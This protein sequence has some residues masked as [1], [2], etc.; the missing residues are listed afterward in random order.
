MPVPSNGFSVVSYGSRSGM[1]ATLNLPTLSFGHWQP[2]YDNPT[3]TFTLAV[4][5]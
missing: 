5:Y 1:F 4:I 3:G 2:R